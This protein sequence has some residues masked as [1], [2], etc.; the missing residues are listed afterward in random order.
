MTI[1][2]VY[3][4]ALQS[5]GIGAVDTFS[6]HQ[7][8]QF[9]NRMP[10]VDMLLTN[11]D[12]EM[13]NYS[14]FQQHFERLKKAEPLAYILGFTTFLGLKLVVDQNVLIPRQET[15][16]LVLHVSQLF[17][18]SSNIKVIDVGTGSGAIA[19]SLKAKR[20]HWHVIATDISDA[21]LKVAKE[22]ANDL[23]L[24][25]PFF[26]GDGL[27][28]MDASYNQQI[29]I[30]VS[31]PPYVED[32]DQLD[33]SVKQFEPHLALIAKP[34]TQFY[35]QYLA[36]G[37]RLLSDKG[38]FAFEIDPSLEKPLKQMTLSMYPTG[39]WTVI[40]DING[41]TRFALLYT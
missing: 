31:N 6:I 2:S 38:I 24:D 37:K 41:K 9:H 28:M 20:P 14:I 11:L 12:R 8:L 15:E 21:A 26:Q 22:N 39:K 30:I 34:N 25:I 10:N 3:Q 13:M 40:K 23:Q 36:E 18:S 29:N 27:K 35:E 16:E 32:E 1:Q 5:I 7:L 4:Q 17:P 33:T 19:L